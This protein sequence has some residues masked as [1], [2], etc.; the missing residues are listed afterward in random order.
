MNHAWEMDLF[1]LLDEVKKELD[2]NPTYRF[3]EHK[4]DQWGNWV[5][6]NKI[7]KQNCT[8]TTT[9]DKKKQQ[10]YFNCKK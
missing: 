10:I 4:Q 5:K 7:L 2:E 3:D 8:W 6:T 9:M 1:E